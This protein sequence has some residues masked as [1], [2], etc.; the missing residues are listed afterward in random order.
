MKQPRWFMTSLCSL[1]CA[2]LLATESG[3][4][5][6]DPITTI[7]IDTPIHFLAADGS[8]MLVQPGTYQLEVA[9]G[10]L[11]LIPGERRD[12]VLLEAH[13]YQHEEILDTPKSLIEEKEEEEHRLIL[14]LPGGK[15]LEAIGSV[16]GVQSRAVKRRPSSRTRSQQ[17]QASRIP[18]QS[19]NNTVSKKSKPIS[20]SPVQP[21][22]PLAQ[23]VQ[24]LEQQV[25][26]LRTLVNTLQSQL[27]RMTSAFQVD[28][29]GNVTISQSGKLTIHASTVEISAGSITTQAG[30]SKFNGVV[31]A[32]T[33]VTNSVVSSS[34]TPGAGNI[35]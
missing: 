28:N 22:D 15:G 34:Y 24:T 18:T 9:E 12:A 1:L 27:N 31:Q 4:T 8:D 26:S 3:A 20:K 21:N 30:M 16:S 14:L 10:W 32:D 13:Q 25:S 17:Q 6:T 33:V 19:K 29:A 23:R 11:R 7:N 2:L 5:T 35:W